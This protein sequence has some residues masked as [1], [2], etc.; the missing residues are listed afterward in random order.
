MYKILST[1]AVLKPPQYGNCSL[2]DEPCEPLISIP[3]VKQLYQ[4]SSIDKTSFLKLKEK[5]DRVVD[6]N[7]N[8]NF[9]FVF[10]DYNYCPPDIIDCVVYCATRYLCNHFLNT[11]TCTTCKHSLLNPVTHSFFLFPAAALANIKTDGHFKHPNLKL[12]NFIQ[13]LETLFSKYCKCTNI[14]DLIINNIYV[15]DISF[16]CKEHGDISLSHIIEYYVSMRMRQYTQKINHE[17]KKINF[18]VKKSAKHY[19]T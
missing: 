16:S 14:Y 13:Y 12:Y 2:S 7:N 10:S 6:N 15:E 17:Q 9:D 11:I 5:L 19:K 1:F 8:W 3:D 4:N 18:H